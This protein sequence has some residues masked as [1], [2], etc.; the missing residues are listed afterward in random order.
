MNIVFADAMN[1]LPEPLLITYTSGLYVARGHSEAT[2]MTI[3]QMP[4]KGI[5]VIRKCLF[6][7]SETHFFLRI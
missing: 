5:F 4:K 2:L 6:Y 7:N 3:C 1:M